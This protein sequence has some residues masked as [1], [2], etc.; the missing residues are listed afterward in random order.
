MGS[1]S[2]SLAERVWLNKL[3]TLSPPSADLVVLHLLPPT[4]LRLRTCFIL[5]SLAFP[6]HGL[7]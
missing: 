2:P 6:S 3:R 4:C 7:A 1:L 5:A